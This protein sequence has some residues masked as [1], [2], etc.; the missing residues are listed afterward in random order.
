MQNKKEKDMFC[1]HVLYV[2]ISWNV[3]DTFFG[4]K[5]VLI[6]LRILRISIMLSQGINLRTSLASELLSRC[7]ELSDVFC[8]ISLQP[9]I[10]HPP[11]HLFPLLP[12]ST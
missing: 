12:R 3:P 4:K 9:L 2:V 7:R 8:L 6:Q 1:V 5:Y 10:S 11:S